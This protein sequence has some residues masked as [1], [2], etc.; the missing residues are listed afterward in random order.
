[1]FF[2]LALGSRLVG[3]VIQR[4]VEPSVARGLLSVFRFSIL[5]FF[6]F[7]CFFSS[8]TLQHWLDIIIGSSKST[9][10]RKAA[11]VLET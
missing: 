4:E 2:A 8:N 9:S 3:N 1:M 5:F 11:K 6:F 7:S 10:G